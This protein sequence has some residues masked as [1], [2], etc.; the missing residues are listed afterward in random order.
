MVRSSLRPS[1][2]VSGP[3]PLRNVAGS[4]RWRW[5]RT[6]GPRILGGGDCGSAL[7][8]RCLKDKTS[9]TCSWTRGAEGRSGGRCRWLVGGRCMFSKIG[10]SCNPEVAAVEEA[11]R[12]PHP[13][14]QGEGS[15]AIPLWE[16]SAASCLLR[17]AL[18]LEESLPP[19]RSR[20]RLHVESRLWAG[21][22]CPGLTLFL[23]VV[24]QGIE[25]V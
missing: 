5:G 3:A 10:A 23:G 22:F 17:T 2:A 25:Q 8:A 14:Q 11:E 13:S 21:F 18:G 24:L 15:A 12:R 9:P 6:A 7:G 1:A 19:P 20:H 16:F 4:A